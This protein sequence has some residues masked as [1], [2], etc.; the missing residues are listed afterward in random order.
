MYLFGKSKKCKNELNIKVKLNSEN[1]CGFK[2]HIITAFDGTVTE[3]E[4]S[5]SRLEDLAGYNLLNFDL[6]KGSELF[7]DKAYNFYQR[8]DEL[9]ECAEVYMKRGKN[10]VFRN[11]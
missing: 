4:F 11:D 5:P 8:E 1:S 9:S 7:M 6:P 10:R 2:V 3:F